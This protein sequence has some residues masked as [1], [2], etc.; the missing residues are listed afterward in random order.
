MRAPKAI[1]TVLG[2]PDPVNPLMPTVLPGAINSAAASAL[3]TLLRRDESQMRERLM[4]SLASKT[5]TSSRYHGEIQLRLIQINVGNGDGA[6]GF[7]RRVASLDRQLEFRRAKKGLLSLFERLDIV[8][9]VRDL[10][11]TEGQARHGRMRPEQKE[12]ELVRIEIRQ[13]CDR[14]EGWRLV[15]GA[16]GIALHAMAGG[17]PTFRDRLAMACVGRGSG[18]W[19]KDGQHAASGQKQ[20]FRHSTFQHGRLLR[21]RLLLGP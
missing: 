8:G 4:A 15:G 5:P 16:F 10:S 18:D 9:K 2:Y 11:P 19:L 1:G 17:A 14:G 21:G 3:T 13:S 20:W 7:G 12:R 6:P